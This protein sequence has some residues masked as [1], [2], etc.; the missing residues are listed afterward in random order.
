MSENPIFICLNGDIV[1]EK[2]LLSI[3]NRAFKYGDGL[4]ETMRARGTR[5]LFFDQHYRRLS[6]SMKLLR[7][8]VESLPTLPE[9]EAAVSRLLYRNKFLK[10]SRLRLTV[11]REQG[12]LYKPQNNDVQYCIEASPLESGRFELNTKGL[13]I[14]IYNDIP[15]FPSTLSALKTTSALQYVM[16][17]N[18]ASLRRFDDC[19]LVNHLGHLVEAT[20]S[21]LFVF[22]NEKMYT[23][24]LSDGC[25]PGI[26][27][28]QIMEIIPSLGME[29]IDNQP[30]K[31]E[32]LHGATEIFFTNAVRGIQWVLAYKEDRYFSRLA[33][34]LLGHLNQKAGLME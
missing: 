11:F 28:N 7:M 20:S 16:A 24:P 29:I 1:P 14:G 17:A 22:K 32:D 8:N 13:F 10:A 12:G 27:R 23:P 34:T 18:Y 6:E 5:I 31:P 19:L 15:L 4:F 25:I 30:L 21:N 2:P 33:K 9:I 26:M 3:Q